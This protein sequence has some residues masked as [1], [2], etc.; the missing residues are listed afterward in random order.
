MKNIRT[1][2]ISFVFLGS[3]LLFA[4]NARGVSDP[5][6]AT[7][8]ADFE[9]WLSDSLTW[10]AGSLIASGTLTDDNGETIS[11]TPGKILPST[12]Y[13]VQIVLGNDSAGTDLKIEDGTSYVRHYNVKGA[14]NW[15]GTSPTLGS[16]A[17]KDFGANNKDNYDCTVSWD[18]NNV[19]VTNTD[20]DEVKIAKLIG[21]I[22]GVSYLITTDTDPNTNSS[23]YMY[24]LTDDSVTEDSS[25]ITITA[26]GDLHQKHYRWRADSDGLNSEA[27]GWLAAE[28]TAYTALAKGTTIR[29]R[30]EIANTSSSP[31]NNYQY[32]LEY[33]TSITGPWT[34][35][36]VTPF[37]S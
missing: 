26:A 19:H 33:S 32:L 10:D 16:G 13:R 8:S 7:G 1:G 12:T 4:N 25:K 15:A 11:C 31:V 2:Y 35:V 28:D 21:D 18:S 27:S 34:A 36:P 9:I 14:G 22:E 23:S 24:V 17:W 3:L 20:G 6:W 37:S 30:A 29:L 5:T